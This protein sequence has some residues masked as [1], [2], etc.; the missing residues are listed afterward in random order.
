MNL[1]VVGGN[2]YLLGDL[3]EK[4]FKTAQWPMGFFAQPAKTGTVT[5]EQLVSMLFP[6]NEL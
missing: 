5:W 3:R 6:L 1:I 2:S 4:S